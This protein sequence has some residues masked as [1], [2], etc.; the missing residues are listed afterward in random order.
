MDR[1]TAIARKRVS[2]RGWTCHRGAVPFI[3]APGPEAALA[4]R[5]EQ[6]WAEYR[7]MSD[8]LCA[9][10]TADLHAMGVPDDYWLTMDWTPIE[11]GTKL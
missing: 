7:E 5:R 11:V 4:E 3:T 9:R 8:A 10:L 6:A 1:E 2:R